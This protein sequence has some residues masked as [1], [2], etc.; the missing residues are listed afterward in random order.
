MQK[1]DRIYVSLGLGDA[2]QKSSNG[3]LSRRSMCLT[4]IPPRLL[5][6]CLTVVLLL[7]TGVLI[8]GMICV[9]IFTIPPAGFD[10]KFVCLLAIRRLDTSFC[11]LRRYKRIGF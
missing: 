3:R 5:A 4:T 7:D 10:T 2:S 9:A 11:G 1:D 8:I 6:L